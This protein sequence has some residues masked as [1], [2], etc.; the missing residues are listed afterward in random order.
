MQNKNKTKSNLIHFDI[1]KEVLKEW[2]SLRIG[3]LE[4]K[5]RKGYSFPQPCLHYKEISF[6]DL[7]G[8]ARD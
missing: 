5:K 4:L 7:P 6:A 1:L 8:Y 2:S 3:I